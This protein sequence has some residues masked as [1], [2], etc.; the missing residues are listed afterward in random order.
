MTTKYG[1]FSDPKYLSPGITY[2]KEGRAKRNDSVG[3]PNIKTPV[4]RSGK[5]NSC[6][7]LSLLTTNRGMTQPLTNSNH[8]SKKKHIKILRRK[9]QYFINKATSSGLGLK[10]VEQTFH[11]KLHHP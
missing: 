9:I 5:V 11:G 1:L 7:S 8:S 2:R 10:Q 4:C 6:Y 3:P